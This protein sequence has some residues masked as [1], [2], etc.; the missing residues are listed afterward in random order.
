MNLSS[1][2]NK[3]IGLWGIG[4]SGSAIA[5]FLLHQGHKPAILDKH[6][7]DSSHS[8]LAQHN[9]TWYQ[10]QEKRT[11]FL[12]E[13]DLIITSPGIDLR[14]YDQHRHKFIAEADLFYAAWQKPIIALTGTLGKTSITTLLSQLLP[15]Q[16]PTTATGGNIGIG[17]LDLVGSDAER[18][19]LEVS[20]FQLEHCNHFAPDLAIWTNLYPNH[21]DRHGD[22]EGY[23]HAKARILKYQKAGQQ[24]LVP[25]ALVQRL[26]AHGYRTDL[27]YA[28]FI[29]TII[30][31]EHLQHLAAQDTLYGYDEDGATVRYANGEQRI[32]LSRKI[33]PA[34]SYPSNWIIIAATLDLLGYNAQQLIMSTTNYELP[35]YRLELVATHTDV[36]YYNDSKSTIM[37]ATLAAVQAL[38]PR[39]VIVLLGGVSKGVDRT[40]YM[41]HLKNY[42]HA[43]I[44][45]GGEAH[46]LNQ[47]C[48]QEGITSV[49]CATLEEAVIA[50]QNY[51][52][53][54]AAVLLSP[55]GASFDLFKHYQERGERFKELVLKL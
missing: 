26:R 48:A 54:D 10:D 9:L 47:A 35:H 30:T 55:G 29:D 25:L 33:I 42:V 12:E 46:A 39:K 24:A 13:H 11:Q 18:A 36:P 5:R 20:S 7:P 22:E 31:T 50:T 2:I 27:P 53:S 44:C 32:V 16:T 51:I 23:F 6:I 41:A 8:L 19:L 3:K 37:E 49:A 4:V 28:V 15:T 21:L 17:M 45:F 38:A 14:P 43:C 1:L 40:P 34:I 52:T